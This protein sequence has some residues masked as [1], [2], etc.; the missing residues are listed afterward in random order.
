ML[1]VRVTN[2][3]DPFCDIFNEKNKKRSGLAGVTPEPR[4]GHFV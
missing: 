2:T 4:C 3:V 1:F